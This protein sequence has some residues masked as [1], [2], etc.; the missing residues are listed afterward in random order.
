MWLQDWGKK[1]LGS[2]RPKAMPQPKSP[3][4]EPI[5]VISVLQ[6]LM[7]LTPKQ[8]DHPGPFYTWSTWWWACQRGE[9]GQVPSCCW[10]DLDWVC[11]YS[12]LRLHAPG[13]QGKHRWGPW[14][15]AE[16]SHCH[17]TS[18]PLVS[19]AH[20]RGSNGLLANTWRRWDETHY[21]LNHSES[22]TS[23][24]VPAGQA[25]AWLS[26]YWSLQVVQTCSTCLRRLWCDCF[27]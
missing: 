2:A 5:I 6:R 11:S 3:E 27:T 26:R 24:P 16:C 25:G 7:I 14:G 17:F 15:L 19:I 13:T 23:H 1:W 10:M 8:I 22:H 12:L 4:E 21:V 18:L 9:W 20:R